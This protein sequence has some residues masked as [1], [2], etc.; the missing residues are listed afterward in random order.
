MPDSKQNQTDAAA[1]GLPLHTPHVLRRTERVPWPLRLARVSRWLHKWVG[2]VLA[3]IMVALSI[4][5]GFVALKNKVEYLQPGARSGAKGDIAEVIP[6]ARV[7]EIILALQLPEAPTVKQINRI[8]LRPSKRMYKVRLEQTSAWRSPRELQVDAMT[9]AIL[10]NGV[11]G[12]QLWMDLHS[13]AVFGETTKLLTMTV[14]G[15][16]L[17]WLS[18]S[19]YYLFFYPLWFRARKRQRLP[20]QGSN[21]ASRTGYH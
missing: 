7:A 15:L 1:L 21:G 6:P 11:R 4:T 9:G 5:G 2:T 3:L 8:E 12:D 13:F 17:L 16:A 20:G 14:S 19:G 10:N 18:L